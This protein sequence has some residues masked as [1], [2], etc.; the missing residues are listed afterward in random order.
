MKGKFFWLYN[1][2]ILSVSKDPF[3]R[4]VSYHP[5]RPSSRGH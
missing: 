3:S 1:S 4:R 2:V 5:K